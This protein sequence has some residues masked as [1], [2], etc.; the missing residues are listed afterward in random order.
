MMLRMKRVIPA[1]VWLLLAGMIAGCGE[2]PAPETQ[3]G[4]A[5]L[6][7]AKPAAMRTAGWLSFPDLVL[8]SVTESEGPKAPY[9]RGWILGGLFQPEG[10]L[11]GYVSEPPPRRLLTRGW[12]DLETRAFVPDAANRPKSRLY[13]EGW[14]DNETGGFFPASPMMTAGATAGT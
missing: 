14:H 6:R 10:E 5:V 3:G 9:L 7:E 12:L 4:G 8:H 13:A 11:V 1:T 2:T